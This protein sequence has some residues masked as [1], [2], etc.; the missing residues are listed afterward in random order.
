MLQGVVVVTLTLQI[1]NLEESSCT[2]ALNAETSV[3]ERTVPSLSVLGALTCG[4]ISRMKMATKI[5]G[6]FLVLAHIH[7]R[8]ASTKQ[9][10]LVRV[11]SNHSL[12]ARRP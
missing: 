5:Q 4:E 6:Q 8:A 10:L 1:L 7:S 11:L 2:F 3:A 9:R 12:L